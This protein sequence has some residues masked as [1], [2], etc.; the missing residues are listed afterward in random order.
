MEVWNARAIERSERV[1]RKLRELC[2]FVL[3]GGWAVYFWT[4]AVKS[5]DIDIYMDFSDFFFLQSK[6]L[7]MGTKLKINRKLKKYEVQIDE[8]EVDIY[9]P[10]M[11]GLI[12]PC[13]DV[14][15]NNWF[16]VIANF[17]VILPEPLLL[18]KLQAESERK[19]SIKGFKDRCDLIALLLLDLDLEF[20]SRLFK[21]Y[22]K[23]YAKRLLEI[24]KEGKEEYNY[25][26]K[27][28]LSPRKLK[29][30]KRRLKDKVKKLIASL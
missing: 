27:A 9:T 15:E 24:V 2:D 30:L 17:K 14:L 16:K 1:L 19:S 8:V 18:L 23:E 6:L 10:S 13:K 28:K 25:A 26:A 4:R 29:T 7:E 22:G 20:L 12:V 11:C 5:I 21:A 3:I